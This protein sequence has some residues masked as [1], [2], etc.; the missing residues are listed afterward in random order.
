MSYKCR[1]QLSIVCVLN[2]E[3]SKAIQCCIDCDKAFCYY[4]CDY[5]KDQEEI[6]GIAWE[7]THFQ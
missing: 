2:C 4:K 3:K 6:D 1:Y 5:L 7:C